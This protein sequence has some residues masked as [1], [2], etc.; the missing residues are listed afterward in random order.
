MFTKAEGKCCNS[1]TPGAPPWQ[2]ILGA[3]QLPP[4]HF[5]GGRTPAG[6]QL[7]KLSWTPPR[8]TYEGFRL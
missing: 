5:Q 6:R 3:L 8:A 7:Q 4:P 1:F 2:V